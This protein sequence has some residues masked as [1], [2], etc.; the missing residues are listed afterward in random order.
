M[1]F[2]CVELATNGMQ[3]QDG[4]V[5]VMKVE[6]NGTVIAREIGESE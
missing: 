5:T 4:M 3:A 6:S 1:D 2:V